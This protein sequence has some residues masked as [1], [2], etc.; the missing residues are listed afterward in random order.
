M[1]NV[2]YLFFWHNEHL[3]AST[4]VKLFGF[5]I[6]IKLFPKSN[7]LEKCMAKLKFSLDKHQ[8]KKLPT[9]VSK[10]SSWAVQE[11]YANLE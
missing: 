10:E 1:K 2:T 7:F 9:F 4:F 3:Q 5:T 6:G 11:K 8:L